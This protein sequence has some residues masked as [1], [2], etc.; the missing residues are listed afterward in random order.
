MVVGVA[1]VAGRLLEAGVV[2]V[3]VVAGRLS[4]LLSFVAGVTVVGRSGLS[5]EVLG[6]LAAEERETVVLLPALPVLPPDTE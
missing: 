1:G 5:K 2:T 6:V 3:V 4:V